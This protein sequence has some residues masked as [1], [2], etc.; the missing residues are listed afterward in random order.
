MK[1]QDLMAFWK[2]YNY[3][4]T[5]LCKEIDYISERGLIY[6]K[7]YIAIRHP[8]F[9]VPIETGKKI[10]KELG[11]L[12]REFSKE[13]KA[14]IE[15]FNKAVLNITKKYTDIDINNGSE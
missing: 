8:S 4:D 3:F 2:C 6:L 15:R 10:E 13:Q 1:Q 5:F 12:Q 14:L 7:D 9:I 11:E